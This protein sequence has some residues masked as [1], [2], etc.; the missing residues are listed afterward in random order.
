MILTL[1]HAQPFTIHAFESL[2][3]IEFVGVED[4]AKKPLFLKPKAAKKGP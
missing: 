1:P 4:V 3:P 2:S